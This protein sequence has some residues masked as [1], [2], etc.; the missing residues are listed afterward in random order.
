MFDPHWQETYIRGNELQLP[1]CA[2][3]F[4]ENLQRLSDADYVPTKVCDNMRASTLLL[5]FSPLYNFRIHT[6]A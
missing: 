2:H 6:L 3:Y 5:P 4:M 1:D